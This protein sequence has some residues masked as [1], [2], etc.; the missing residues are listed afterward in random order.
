MCIRDSLHL[1]LQAPLLQAKPW[2]ALGVVPHVRRWS[3][4]EVHCAPTQL[5]QGQSGLEGQ[6]QSGTTE[7]SRW[8]SCEADQ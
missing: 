5:V 6:N 3:R 8:A 4:C 1:P 2:Q 7:Q